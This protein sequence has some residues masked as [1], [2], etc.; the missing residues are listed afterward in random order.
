MRTVHIRWAAAVLH[1]W[2]NS[3]KTH[4]TTHLC[5]CPHLGVGV[6]VGELGCIEILAAIVDSTMGHAHVAL[7]Q[8][9]D[10]PA[11][12]AHPCLP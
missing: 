11:L 4:E 8:V 3:P 7:Y 5:M 10:H 1:S 2:G 12:V 9:P 6:K